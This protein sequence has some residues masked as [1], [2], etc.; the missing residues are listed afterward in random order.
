MIVGRL[1]A[2]EH[3]YTRREERLDFD[4]RLHE[5]SWPPGFRIKDRKPR[6]SSARYST[7]I[8][9]SL[10][11]QRIYI[12][13]VP[14]LPIPEEE[15]AKDKAGS[16]RFRQPAPLDQEHTIGTVRVK[17]LPATTP[18]MAM[19][20]TALLADAGKR[21]LAK[22]ALIRLKVSFF[23]LTNVSGRRMPCQEILHI[24]RHVCTS[25]DCERPRGS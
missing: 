21:N 6:Q 14:E 15:L 23:L 24:G 5:Q 17:R 2:S 16:V 4:R 13:A 7:P 1:R 19:S 18:R 3:T 12:L 10:S 8:K 25:T 20:P 9:R 11:Q 22:G